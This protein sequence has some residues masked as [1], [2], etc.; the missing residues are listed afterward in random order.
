MHCK[1]V[2]FK[3][4]DFDLDE[5]TISEKM[6]DWK[7][8]R[9]AE[10]IVLN[11]GGDYAVVGVKKEPGVG[12]FQKVTEFEILALPY[13]TD[14]VDDPTVDVLNMPALASIQLEHPG[15]AVVIR[16]MFS[17]VVFIRDIEPLYLDVV[18][19]VPPSP[20]KLGVLVRMALASDF[21]DL[22]IVVRETVIDMADR[23]SEVKTQAV[24]FPCKVSGLTADMPV[25]YLDD[26]P[27]VEHDVTLIGCNLSKRIYESLYRKEVP[28]LNVCPDDY[29]QGKGKCIVK[30]CKI[31]QD[32]VI[33][34]SV[35]KVP[36]GATV[37]EIVEA[38]K[39]LFSL[40]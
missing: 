12:L 10:Y 25:Y 18:D 13:E 36:W 8:Y 38:I 4:V 3:T 29:T 40:E 33:E 22:P 6:R 17:H 11:N 14:F 19:N 30:C 35:A 16:G 37:P 27:E 28:F 2:S 39:D 20:S 21:I 26:A 15:R 1:D 7:A 34:G 24:M 23:I 31:K 9:R 32:H 5:R